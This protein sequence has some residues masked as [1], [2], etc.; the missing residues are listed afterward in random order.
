M[1]QAWLARWF[2]PMPVPDL[3]DAAT[4]EP[5]LLIN[6]HYRVT[7]PAARAAALAAQPDVVGDPQHLARNVT[8]PRSA[9]ARGG[10]RQESS[11][12]AS[13]RPGRD[14]GGD[15]PGPAPTTVPT[16]PMNPCPCWT[17][18]RRARP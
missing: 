3:R 15:D 18:R 11:Q 2:E 14:D 6:D 5:M 8:D 1:A 17:T 10:R 12:G 4:G 9:T 16:G 7:D 13:A